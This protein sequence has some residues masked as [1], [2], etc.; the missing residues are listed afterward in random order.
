MEYLSLH[1]S[2]TARWRCNIL[3]FS[4]LANKLKWCEDGPIFCLWV[5]EHRLLGPENEYQSCFCA[6]FSLSSVITF[7]THI[8]EYYESI[9]RPLKLWSMDGKQ[10]EECQKIVQCFISMVY[11][12]TT[13]QHDS[14]YFM[15]LFFNSGPFVDERVM[16]NICEHISEI[17]QNLFQE[18]KKKNYNTRVCRMKNCVVGIILPNQDWLDISEMNYRKVLGL[19]DWKPFLS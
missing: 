15:R 3:L 19:I 11:V 8:A 12:N 17:F 6:A 14:E 7:H 18:M 4:Q 1:S 9:D 16:V 5:A 13:V 2:R 10:F